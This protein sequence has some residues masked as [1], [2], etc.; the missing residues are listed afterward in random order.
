MLNE[1]VFIKNQLYKRSLIHDQ[2][3]GSRQGG[4]S[5]SATYPFIFLFSG[6][7]GNR[8]GYTDRWENENIYSYTG[9]GQLND[10]EF[11]RGNLILRDHIKTN[12]RV[13]LFIYVEKAYVKFE[14]ELTLLT[15][16][17]F[18]ALDLMGQKR[19]AIKFFFR[20]TDI[21]YPEYYS[22]DSIAQ[23]I[24]EKEGEDEYEKEIPNKTERQ[25][26][27]T[28]RVGQ[29]AY[30]KSILF[31]WNFKCAVT[32]YSNKRILIASHIVP[33]KNST[34]D[35]RL[36]V[37]NGILL[38]PVYDALF[39]QNLISFE[40][41]GKIILSSSLQKTDF[42]LIGINGNECIKNLSSGNIS[43]LRRH[44]QQLD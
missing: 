26:L 34:N 22:E 16:D 3:R 33:W 43:Y 18:Q 28:S 35:E 4:I 25:G 13:F 40:N 27:I 9:E 23:H 38:S 6:E 19:L 1:P 20:R 8:H 24:S 5:Y 12:R 30:R 29:G 15:F 17:F 44:R 7:T 21:E 31:R 42:K 39:D 36:D 41:N 11:V 37:D 2:Y 14:S 32:N 10:M